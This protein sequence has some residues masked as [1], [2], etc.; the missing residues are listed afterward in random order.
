MQARLK[1]GVLLL[2]CAGAASAQ[3]YR[4]KD[5]HGVTHF[6]D[7]PPAASVPVAKI[8]RRVEPSP[9]PG[10]PFALAQ[11]VKNNPVTLYTTAQ[12]A[13]CDQ[14]RAMLQARGIPY[15]E[16]TVGNANDHAALRLAG[17]A[18]QL[19]LLL[20]GPGKFIGYEQ[21]TWDAALTA[22]NYPLQAMLPPDYRPVPPGPAA[23]AADAGTRR[24]DEDEARRAQLPAPKAT[25]DFQF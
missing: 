5:A 12:C 22:A 19:P 14:A 17:G 2:L 10:L 1:C 9:A 13:A 20:I 15:V 11:A 25:P 3:M 7:T 6:S 23:P 24:G 21:A 4:W 18:S 16:K 8:D